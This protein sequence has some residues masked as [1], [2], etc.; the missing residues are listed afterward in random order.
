MHAGE[1]PGSKRRGF[2]HGEEVMTGFRWMIATAIGFWLSSCATSGQSTY[3]AQSRAFRRSRSLAA[4]TQPDTAGLFRAATLDRAGL[5]RAVLDRNPSLEA[6]R[7]SWGAALARYRQVA[8]Y[9]EPTVSLGVAPLS[10]TSSHAS[11]G[12]EFGVRQP[13][14]LGGKADARAELAIAGADV[15]END[16]R[17]L[18]LALSLQAAL[19]YADYW[20]AQRALAIS[21]EHITLVTSLRQNALA[22]YATGRAALQ[23][24]LQADAELAQLD[25]QKVTLSAERDVLVA[26]LNTLLHR[27]PSALLPPAPENL[28]LRD[29]VDAADGGK[30]NLQSQPAKQRPELIGGRARVRMEEARMASAAGDYNPS[31]AV[32]MS[33]NSLWETPA[34]R[35][36]A[37]VEVSI[38]LQRERRTAALDEAHASRA[39]AAQELEHLDDDV[40]SQVAM[41]RKRLQ[42]SRESLE[43]RESR[44]VPVAREQLDATR[45]AFSSEQASFAAVIESARKLR[46]AQLDL[47]ASR[48]ALSK[49]SAELDRALGKLV[50]F[51]GEDAQP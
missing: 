42:A 49:S 31:L 38:P 27:S 17:S 39:A 7:M 20:F 28:P 8:S 33:Y 48:A 47:E 22:G 18:R 43:I 16:F 41:A 40:R 1:G 25:D 26:Q 13:I 51:S 15:R 14:S 29:D 9:D 10:I 11:F 35:F 34:H 12:Y 4:V 45:F 24:S 44:S 6:A 5:I 2:G 21:A 37:G 50:G 30:T 23:D 19:L 36:V 32:S 3:A 46:L